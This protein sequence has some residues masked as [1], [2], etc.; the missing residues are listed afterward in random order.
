M[1]QTALAGADLR[2]VDTWLFDLDNTLYSQDATDVDDEP[3]L[4]DEVQR[5]TGL[6]FGEALAL[7]KSYL[8]TYGTTLRGLMIH[9][10]V[11]PLAFLARL[12]DVPL[13]ALTADP[14]LARGLRRLPGRRLIFTNADDVHAERVLARLG[15]GG[16]FEDVFHIV[17]ADFFPKPSPESFEKLIARHAIEPS[18]TAFFEDRAAN[19]APAHRLGM[20]TVLVGACAEANTDAFVTHRVS[21]LAPFLAAALVRETP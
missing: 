20:T 2:H 5:V 18:A 15:L 14:D 13:D 1:S 10:D 21:R 11:E 6:P 19:L 16:L 8:D 4:T 9:H 7:R 3:R 12:H 17:A